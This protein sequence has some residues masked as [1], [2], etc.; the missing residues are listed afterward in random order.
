MGSEKGTETNYE[1]HYLGFP[2]VLNV[3]DTTVYRPNFFRSNKPDGIKRF[4]IIL[5]K[6]PRK[7]IFKSKHGGFSQYNLKQQSPEE[8]CDSGKEPGMIP[9]F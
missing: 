1:S 9:S 8:I 4:L 6:R 2:R 5:T 7:A 3:W